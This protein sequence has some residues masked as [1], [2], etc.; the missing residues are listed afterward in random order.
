MVPIRRLLDLFTYAACLFGVLPLYGFLGL[1]S[2]ILFPVAFGAGFICDWRQRYFLNRWL[3]TL[4]SILPF[5]FY[6]LRLSLNN[7]V[8]PA[9]NVLV[10]LLAVRLLT[11]KRPRNYLQIFALA[12]FTLAGSSLLSLS[13]LFMPALVLQMVSITIGLV[14]LT[15]HASD[16]RMRLSAGSLRSLFTVSLVL[17]IGSL[18]LMLVLFAVLPRT[19]YPLWSF[20]N[21]GQKAVSG[22]SESVRPGAFA[23][24]AASHVPVFR[25]EC[26]PLAQEDLYWRGIVLNIAEGSSWRR[27]SP[28]A[29]E[30][31]RLSGG[32]QVVQIFYPETWQDGYLFTLDPTSQISDLHVHSS[33]DLVHH[34]N[35][36]RKRPAS[37]RAISRVGAVLNASGVNREFY[38][39]L[40]PTVSRRLRDTA[41]E[42]ASGVD[43][44]A[45]KIART[46]EFFRRQQLVYAN[47]DLPG[48]ERPLEEF[49][50][51]KRRGYCEF[52]ASSFA[53]LLRLE[54]VPTRLVG[55]YHGGIRNEMAGYYGI[56]SDMA[57][58]W[59]EALVDGCWQR[60]DPSSLAVNAAT[61][62]IAG[63]GNNPGW[64]R[65]MLDAADFY[66]NRAV[67][68]YDFEQ[69]LQLVQNTAFRVHGIPDGR[70]LFFIAGWLLAVV[71]GVIGGF[72]L[73]GVC[74]L[75]REQRLLRRFQQMLKRRFGMTP[76]PDSAGLQ[77]VAEQTGDARCMEFAVIW[78]GAVYRDRPLQASERKRLRRL[79]RAL[80]RD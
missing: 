74:S 72:R 34:V 58:V 30:W 78:C 16:D 11:E 1:S 77:T 3:A 10:M 54:G 73:L 7:V 40:P 76:I 39:Q 42:L 21:P 5:A 65:R 62:A 56:T 12:I 17:P 41:T 35:K 19:Q 36:Y 29:G 14:L 31:L 79:L 55:G 23:S 45:D 66:W 8:D 46:Q 38:L 51:G 28:P 6:G 67:I 47:S 24:N 9:V 15:F 53:L 63:R 4:L 20:L 25:V 48:P 69:Q 18:L 64:G 68:S 49:L 50:F 57:H 44:A 32:R 71:L 22:F 60:I 70:R 13:S 80:R 43:D 37:Y 27:E 33:V 61:A 2:K 59:V 75:S 52:F 26:E